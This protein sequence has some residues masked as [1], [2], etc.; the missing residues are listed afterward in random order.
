MEHLGVVMLNLSDWISATQKTRAQ[1]ARREE[2]RAA[3]ALRRIH[4]KWE[5]TT[6]V[7]FKN[8]AGTLLAEQEVRIES[9]NSATPSESAAGV[10]PRRKVVVYG[11]P[12][13]DIK[14][15]YRF[16]YANDEYRCV[17]VIDTLGERQGVFEAIG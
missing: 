15:G 11:V 16:V 7:V 14:E 3:H 6:T 8:A 2:L 9:D 5:V 4:D 10:A 12:E 17:D 13:T 1:R